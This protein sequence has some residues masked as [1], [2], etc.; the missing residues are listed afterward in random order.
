MLLCYRNSIGSTKLNVTLNRYFSFAYTRESV[1]NRGV[2]TVYYCMCSSTSIRFAHIVLK[3]VFCSTD[4]NISL[5]IQTTRRI[6]VVRQ[7]KNGF[8]NVFVPLALVI[9]IRTD[10]TRPIENGVRTIRKLP[11]IYSLL[12]V[13]A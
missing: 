13:Y 6:T 5:W 12:S 1:D 3:R 7:F 11:K 9:V 10:T 4:S 8:R 2:C